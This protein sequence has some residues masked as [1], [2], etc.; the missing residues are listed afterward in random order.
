MFRGHKLRERGQTNQNRGCLIVC[1]E[2][3][4][5]VSKLSICRNVKNTFQ[6]WVDSTGNRMRNR[7]VAPGWIYYL[8][9][10]VFYSNAVFYA[11]L[12]YRGCKNSF[13]F[14]FFFFAFFAFFC[15]FFKLVL[16]RKTDDNGN[17][18]FQSYLSKLLKKETG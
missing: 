2:V 15:L 10:R 12:V 3:M 14:L 16:P 6:G 18:M 9:T 5:I 1:I 13:F 17:A 11:G 4:D 7:K 8:R